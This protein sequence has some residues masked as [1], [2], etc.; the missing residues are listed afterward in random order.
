MSEIKVTL[1]DG[2]QEL[3]DIL[4]ANGRYRDTDAVLQ[5]GLKLLEDREA[6]LEDVREGLREG[7]ADAR[8]GRTKDGPA[9]IQ[10]AFERAMS[11]YKK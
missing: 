2:Q 5:A 8:A 1:T 9:A 3:V 4:V 11:N 10:A 6:A 7:L